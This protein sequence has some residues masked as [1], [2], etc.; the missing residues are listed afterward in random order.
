VA[1]IPV[2]TSRRERQRAE[3][4]RDLAFA[5]LRLASEHGLAGVL[6]PDVAA[7]AGVSPRTFNNYFRSR[8]AAIAWPAVRRAGDLALRL[9][10]RPA[11]EPLRTAILGALS[12]V[13]RERAEDSAEREWLV[14]LNTLAESEPAVRA[15]YLTASD[16]AERALSDAI[17]ARVDA[18]DSGFRPM[19]LAAIIT[20]AE[21]AAVRWWLS[22]VDDRDRTLSQAVQAAVREALSG[23]GR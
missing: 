10:S 3:T 2:Q 22:A 13:Y 4:R 5:A 20:G 15:E 18:P 7:A 9:R 23:L 6:V 12:Q 14:D 16:A 17:A 11:E 8:E 1:A 19:L 21:R